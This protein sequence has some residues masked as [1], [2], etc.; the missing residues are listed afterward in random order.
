[1]QNNISLQAINISVVSEIHE[2]AL[3]LST[4][5]QVYQP[6]PLYKIVLML[7]SPLDILYLVFSIETSVGAL[8][9][10]NRRM[11]SMAQVR[12]V[13]VAPEELGPTMSIK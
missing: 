2:I 6:P 13:A 4:S 12:S 11:T 5:N 10:A 9:Q 1:M 7:L 3:F 8:L